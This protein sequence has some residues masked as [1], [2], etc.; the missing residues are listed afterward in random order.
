M[1]NG[2]FG[3]GTDLREREQTSGNGNQP[4]GTGNG[5]GAERWGVLIKRKE[6]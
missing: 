4:P 6:P 1:G 2:P 5:L 3:T